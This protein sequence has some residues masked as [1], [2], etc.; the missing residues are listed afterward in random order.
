MEP[1]DKYIQDAAKIAKLYYYNDL[2]TQQIA[3]EL[4]VSR[5]TV[6]RLLS[7]AK[8]QGL[9]EIRVRDRQDLLLPMEELIKKQFGLKAVHIVSVPEVLDEVIWLER[10]AKYA[11][12]YLN[13]VLKPH[14]ILGIAWGTTM[15]AVSEHLLPTSVY[16]LSIVQLNGSGNT[17]IYDNSYAATILKVFAD[18]YD[19]RVY[20]L[21]VPTF[22]DH[23][24]TKEAMWRERSVRQVVQLQNKAD[25]L[26][27]SIGAVSAGVPSHIHAGG[28]LERED[29]ETLKKDRVIGDIATVFFRAD[30]SWA[31]IKINS[32]A[33]GPPLTL[34]TKVRHGVCVVSGLA[35]AAGLLAALRAGYMT[36]L[37]VD[38]PTCRLVLELASEDRRPSS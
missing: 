12:N 16:D 32:R 20:L 24:E 1:K 28:Y 4:N 23:K 30:G 38:A 11:A 29:Q 7:L 6:S 27:Y 14:S 13:T 10:V 3:K 34:F 5:P 15:S 25:V 36:E 33:S 18:T 37:I 19:A 26:L 17:Y 21:P 8:R 31:D 22:F 35:K 9:V 2:T